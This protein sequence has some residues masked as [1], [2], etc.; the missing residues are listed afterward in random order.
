MMLRPRK[1]KLGGRGATLKPAL[2]SAG[3]L[4]AKART[5]LRDGE[6]RGTPLTPAQR[7]MFGAAAGRGRKKPSAGEY[8]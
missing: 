3:I 2:P 6:V 8:V 4:P 1:A 5:I 7:G